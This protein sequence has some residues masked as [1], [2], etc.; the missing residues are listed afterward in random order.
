MHSLTR[1]GNDFF[2][3]TDKGL[4]IRAR[5]SAEGYQEISRTELILPATKDGFVYSA[6]A[7]ANGHVFVR[8]DVELLCASLAAAP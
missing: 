1:C 5:V 3:F 2:I 4:L 8:N 7:Y 6:P